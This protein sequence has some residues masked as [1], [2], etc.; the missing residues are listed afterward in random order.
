MTRAIRAD[1]I[2]RGDAYLVHDEM[3]HGGR[4]LILLRDGAARE[5]DDAERGGGEAER[6]RRERRHGRRGRSDAEK[7]TLART[8]WAETTRAIVF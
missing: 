4:G 1:R 2:S 8:S 5:G 6:A 3:G 7:L